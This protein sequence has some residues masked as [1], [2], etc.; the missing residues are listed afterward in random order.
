MK[1]L[2]LDYST[3]RSGGDGP[4]K[5][6]KGNTALLNRE[7]SM[8]CLGQFAPQL[9]YG[10]KKD[11]MLD[12]GNPADLPKKIPGLSKRDGKNDYYLDTKL[13]TTAI[14][15]NDDANTTPQEKIILL[16]RLF[17]KNGYKIK[18]INCPMEKAAEPVLA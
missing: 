4:N 15:I 10:I 9:N 1:I 3:W 7:G 6:G 17:S 11:C 5:L 16:K 13:S 12:Q 2:I 8:C 18:V 14:G